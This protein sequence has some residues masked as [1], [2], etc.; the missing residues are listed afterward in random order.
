MQTILQQFNNNEGWN[1]EK[2][3]GDL[4]VWWKKVEKVKSVSM[5]FETI[6]DVPLFNLV[7]LFYEIDLYPKVMPHC[8]RTTPLAKIGKARKLFHIEYDM[9]I[10][11]RR[12]AILL[13]FGVD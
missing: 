1:V 7:S 10:I 4:K 13:G 8:S 2:N 12:D 6:L 9:S 11:S 5:K 3:T